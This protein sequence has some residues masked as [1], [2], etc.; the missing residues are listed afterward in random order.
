MSKS[1]RDENYEIK[2][3]KFGN[4]KQKKTKN[5]YFFNLKKF[6]ILKQIKKLIFNLFLS[7]T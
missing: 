2:C 1:A 7:P 3:K 4:I 5:I 6:K